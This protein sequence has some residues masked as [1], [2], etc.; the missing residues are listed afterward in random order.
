M[1]HRKKAGVAIALCTA[2][3]LSLTAY[4]P[5]EQQ[6]PRKRNLKVLPQN[7][8]RDSLDHLM[9][10]YNDALGVKC[11]FCH[12]QN[13]NNPGKLDFG[14]DEKPE[15]EIARQMITM[16][17]EINKKYF[18]FNTSDTAHAANA[19]TCTTCHRGEAKP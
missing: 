15:K 4:R 7:I 12:A 18:T 13:A 2:A 5:T 11:G 9:H 10:G 8:S 17:M 1:L 16:T 3:F 6:Q 14:S 19:V